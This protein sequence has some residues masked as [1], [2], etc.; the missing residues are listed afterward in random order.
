[1]A[2]GSLSNARTKE[3]GKRPMHSHPRAWI[4]EF[5]SF[6]RIAIVGASRDPK[7]F[8]RYVMDEFVKRGYDVT[9][10]NPN[11]DEI[12]GLKC[13]RSLEAMESVPEGV[14]VMT[15]SKQSCEMVRQSA[16][17]GVKLVWLYKAVAGGAVS[18]ET[19]ETCDELGVR[20]IAG[21]CPLMF[22]PDTAWFHRM[23]AGWR[24]LT[25]TMPR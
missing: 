18:P 9:P 13:A 22:F 14:M 1:M 10:V 23:H 3:T 15:T 4:D 21:E 17:R 24:M 7:H 12:A 5:L 25:G 20:V 16:A 19:V 11:A 8:S 2:G 6:K